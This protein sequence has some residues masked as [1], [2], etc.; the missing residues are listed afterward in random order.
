LNLLPILNS[1]M[2]LDPR[3]KGLLNLSYVW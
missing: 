3:T 1:L 2:D